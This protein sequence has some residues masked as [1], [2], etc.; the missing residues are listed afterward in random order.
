MSNKNN[1][2]KSFL[3]EVRVSVLALSLAL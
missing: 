3:A 2:G 1:N